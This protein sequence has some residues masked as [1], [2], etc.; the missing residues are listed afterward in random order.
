MAKHGVY[1]TQQATAGSASAVTV[2]ESGIPFVIGTA[3]LQAAEEPAAVGVPIL[4]TG[5]ADFVKKFGYSDDWEKYTLCEFAYSHFQLYGCAPAI[6]CNLVDPATMSAAVTA[7]D[8]TVSDHRV[9]LPIEAINDSTLVVKPAGGSGTAY[10]KGTDY[11]VY[12]DGEYCVV[13]ALSSGGCYSATSL[14]VAYKGVVTTSINA[15]AVATGMQAID[16]CMTTVG[17]IPDLICAPGWSD[18]SS[19]AAVMATKAESLNGV[20]K[21]KAVVD[22]STAASGG[23]DSYDEVA[24]VKATANL[25]DEDIVVCWPLAKLGERTFHMSTHVAGLMAKVDTDNGGCPYESPSNKSLQIDSLVLASG[26]VVKQTKAQ[27]DT[28]V[29]A[30]V[31]TALNFLSSGWVCWGN[32]TAAYPDNADLKDYFIPISRMFGWVGNTLVQSFWK[33]LDKPMNRR[34]V[35][36]ILDACNIWLNG[37]VGSGYMLGARAVMLDDENPLEDLMAGIMKI[38]IYMT[39]PSPAQ[40]IDFT[41]EYDA[42]YVS[43]AFQG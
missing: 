32:Y 33:K 29:A 39:P 12:Y 42:S 19:V 23:A 31:V 20:F 4:V 14:N 43:A 15:A 40:E 21:C 17:H 3:P 24:S 22:L 6:F 10:V 8:M 11:T 34:L 13:E 36:T 18:V 28:V 26:A 5:W 41:L 7:A 38:H 16:L 35:D 9:K 2:A 30:G 25:S 27:A 1:V 37:L